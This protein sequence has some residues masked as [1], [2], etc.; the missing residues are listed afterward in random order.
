MTECKAVST[1]MDVSTKLSGSKS[2]DDEEDNKVPYR[3]LIGSLMYIAM[4]TR[5]DIAHAVSY[6]SCY[7]DCHKHTHWVAAKRVLRYLKA[8]LDYTI[9]YKSTGGRPLT[10]FVDADWGSCP[11]DRRSYTGYAFILAGGCITWESRKQRTLSSTEAEYMGISDAFKEAIYLRKF[12]VEIGLKLLRNITVMCDNIGAQKIATNPVF[13]SRTKYI[14]I[15]HY[16]VRKMLNSG[17]VNIMR[18][19][20]DD[21][22]DVLTKGLP[23]NKHNKCIKLL[24]MSQLRA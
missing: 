11:D 4:G 5:P 18:V 8:T 10:G 23:S 15:R 2:L 17:Y 22:A 19:S 21:M 12:L 13:H 14:D 9:N 20:T 3:E 16:F 7:N 1:P 6:P 24:G